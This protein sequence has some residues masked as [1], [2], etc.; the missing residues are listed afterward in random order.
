MQPLDITAA[1]NYLYRQRQN[2]WYL[3]PLGNFALRDGVF[4]HSKTSRLALVLVS[5]CWPLS[6]HYEDKDMTSV[7]TL[8]VLLPA[9][10]PEELERLDMHLPTVNVISFAGPGESGGVPASLAPIIKRLGTRVNWFALSN[11]PDN[12]DTSGARRGQEDASQPGFSYYSPKVPAWLVNSHYE[13]SH[14]YLYPLLH[15]SS[16]QSGFDPEAWKSYRQLCESVASECLTMASDSFPTLCW[17]HD[18][19]LALA[20]PVLAGEAGLVL[21]QFWHVPWPR[22]EVIKTSPVAKELI[23]ALLKNRL[24]GFQTTEYADN[25]FASAAAVLHDCKVDTKQRTI[26]YDG[27]T[28]R[29]TVMPLGIDLPFWQKLAMGAKPMSE[30]L[31]PKHSLASQ[32][33]LSVER[34]EASKR[35]C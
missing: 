27:H 7:S 20:A 34:L 16:D 19:Q 18:Y 10:M 9:I 28:T 6:S 2:K 5:D 1:I 30:A 15:G 8:P 11:L 25:F 17:L 29:I 4:R 35:R 32:I 13:V 3:C 14:D 24:I 22:A 21:C 33:I 23:E 31:I 26:T 12:K